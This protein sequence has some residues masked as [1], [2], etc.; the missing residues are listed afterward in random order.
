M[1]TPVRWPARHR[2]EVTAD[3]LA[4][5]VVHWADKFDGRE[6]DCIGEI[7]QALTE[8]AEGDR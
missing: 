1:G 5:D 3:R 4:N 6:K 2:A 7:I 8:I